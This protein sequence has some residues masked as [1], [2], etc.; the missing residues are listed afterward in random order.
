MPQFFVRLCQCDRGPNEL[1]LVLVG[2]REAHHQQLT[3]SVQNPDTAS[4]ELANPFESSP[5]KR[6][7]CVSIASD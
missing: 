7:P 6:I 5:D 4:T 1:P 3:A 2:S